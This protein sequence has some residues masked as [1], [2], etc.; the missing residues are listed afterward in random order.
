MTKTVLLT[1]GRLPK[2]LEL[3]RSF[4]RAGW[5]VV[6][7]EPFAWHVSRLSNAVAKSNRVAAPNDDREQYLKDILAII[8]EQRIDLVLPVS[9]ETMHV[10]ALHKRLPLGVTMFAPSH[11]VL[12]SLH[13]KHA[14]VTRCQQYGLSVPETFA[15]ASVEAKALSLRGAHVIKPVFSCSGR[16][17]KIV[18]TSA[19]LSPEDAAPYTIVQTFIP[20]QVLSSFSIAH[21]G[22]ALVTSIYKGTVMSG[23][24]SVAFERVLDAPAVTD[25][26]NSFIEK[27]SHSGFISFDFVQDDKGGVCAIECNPRATSG[28]HF[29]HPDDLARAITEP[30]NPA[31]VRFKDETLFQQFYPCLTE[32][33]KSVFNP[34]LRRNNLKNLFGAKD[35]IWQANDPLPFLLM[36]VTSYKILALSIFKGLSFGEASTRDIEW[37][38]PPH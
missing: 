17:V 23:T 28:V 15:A 34:V 38:P 1:L 22:R 13:D 24:V 16:G 9:E 26:I 25:W 27:S 7:A 21:N 18:K 36:P 14:F 12:L 37:T 19:T 4:N 33:Q 11:D 5:R 29:I 20:G 35:V 2:A 30:E 32:T 31:P 8:K 6:I 10:A 3:A